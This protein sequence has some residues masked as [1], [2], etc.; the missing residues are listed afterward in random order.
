MTAY[1]PF[2]R[3]ALPVGVATAELTD[4]SRDRTLP[5]EI[6]YPATDEHRGRDLDPAHQ[7]RFQTLPMAPQA[8]QA[9][10]RDAA[11]R[12]GV[13]PLV[14]FSHGF[15]GERRQTTHFCTHLA[16]HGYAVAS[17]DHVGNTTADLLQAAMAVQSGGEPPDPFVL[18][19]RFVDDRPADASFVIDRALAGDVP[20][21]IDAERIGI[22]GHSF[23][24]WTTLQTTGRDRRIRAA[25][26]LA[27]AGGASPL[28]EARGHDPIGDALGL[29]WGREVPT[30]FLVA[31]LD[32]LLPLDGM[33][34]LIERTPQPR[35][36]VVLKNADHFHFCDGVA[37]VHD[38]FKMM[39]P[40]M[41]AGGPMTGIDTQSFF[42][43]MK[44]SSELCPG[45]HAYQMI[46]GL[47]LAHMDAHLRGSEQAAA[48]LAGDLGALLAGRGIDAEEL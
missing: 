16:S 37:Q 14:V 13:F 5:V 42:A 48:L 26:P 43:A 27:P 38:L 10:V 21:G 3:G 9:A 47:G 2:R 45:E 8:S 41:Q 4:A 20:V 12:D 29:E 32:T 30:L 18:V 22:T 7:D 17:M 33:R 36:A 46:Q 11:A 35:R 44:P 34:G 24:G 19:Q 23:G 40:M 6:W 15:G 31:D 1:D 39:G 28:T 25:L